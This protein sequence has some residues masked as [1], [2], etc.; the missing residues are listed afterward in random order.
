MISVLKMCILRGKYNNNE[1]TL[2]DV[3]MEDF[4]KIL[5]RDSESF[6]VIRNK[7]KIKINF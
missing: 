3:S 5:Y 1:E 4:S 7:K 2:K 6:I